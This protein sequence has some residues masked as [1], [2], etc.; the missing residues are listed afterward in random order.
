MPAGYGY[1]GVPP[2]DP[3]A[4]MGRR[5]GAFFIDLAIAS[6]VCA[7]I[8]FVI[9]DHTDVDGALR[10]HDC[11]IEENASGQLDLKCNGVFFRSGTDVFVVD[12]GPALAVGVVV[13]LLAYVLV[14]TLT[15]GATLG[16]LMVGLRA[17][18]PDGQPANIG[19][20]ALRWIVML[21]DGV[22]T[23]CICGL[24]TSLVSKGHRR[25]GDMAASTYVV[26]RADVGRPITVPGQIAP[27]GMPPP[28][29]QPQWDAARNAY[30]QW[31]QAG[32]RW[33][34]WDEANQRW[35]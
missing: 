13:G 27:A 26:G 25:L 5:I 12:V 32:G 19:R 20:H 3:T 9:G 14:P 21:I 17:V 30:V 8:F 16:K 22:F 29:A 35:T 31:D 6:L 10:D 7:A 1:A 15:G 33:L 2:H 24:V 4:V 34:V 11:R 23:L 18:G 28:G